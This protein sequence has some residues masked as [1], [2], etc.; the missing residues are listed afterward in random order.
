ME[1][2]YLLWYFISSCFYFPLFSFILLWGCSHRERVFNDT[3]EASCY[4]RY[5]NVVGKTTRAAREKITNR[6][7]SHKLEDTNIVNRYSNWLEKCCG[8]KTKILANAF[9]AFIDLVWTQKWDSLSGIYLKWETTQRHFL[10]FDTMMHPSPY[11][12]FPSSLFIVNFRW[13]FSVPMLH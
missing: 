3:L 6:N 10:I 1:G 5:R 7:R 12:R 11:I 4:N 9:L 8:L 2:W 13:V